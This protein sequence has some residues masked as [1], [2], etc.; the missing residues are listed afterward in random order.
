MRPASEAG[1]YGIAKNAGIDKSSYMLCIFLECFNL[2]TQLVR[3]KSL[4]IAL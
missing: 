4:Q 3:G 2:R 1:I